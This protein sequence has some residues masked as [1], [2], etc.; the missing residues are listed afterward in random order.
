MGVVAVIFTTLALATGTAIPPASAQF[1]I[2]MIWLIVLSAFG[3]Y[4]LYWYLL[5]RVG[6]TR[7]N[8]LMFLIPTITTAGL[9]PAL[10]AVWIV[11]RTPP[12]TTTAI[13]HDATA[14]DR[15]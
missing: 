11:T 10:A 8:T 5:Q 3:G 9:A 6:V 12:P 2:V 1:W 4:G 14:R 15:E 7:V 13:V